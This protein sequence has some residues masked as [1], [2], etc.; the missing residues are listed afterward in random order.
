[1]KGIKSVF[2]SSM[3]SLGLMCAVP[4][5]SL[6]EMGDAGSMMVK[7]DAK[8][9]TA[10]DGFCPVCLL[11]GNKIMGNPEFAS[12]YEGKTYMFS[13]ADT[14]AMFDANPAIMV[15]MAEVKFESMKAGNSS[16]D[17]MPAKD[18][19]INLGDMLKGA[20][21]KDGAA[22]KE[23]VKKDDQMA[24]DKMK[25]DAAMMMKEEVKKDGDVMKDGMKDGMKD[26]K[27]GMNDDAG[28]MKK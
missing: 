25:I 11:N 19:M 16:A 4:V 24:Q 10:L 6:A 27:D 12:V 3:L 21:Q 17:A 5:L 7:Q 9:T 22:M 23:E 8:A 15:K 1:M 26:V 18:G 14:K 28:M 20:M 13:S 2:V